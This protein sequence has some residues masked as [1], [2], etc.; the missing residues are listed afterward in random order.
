MT[1]K[2]SAV[3]AGR[4]SSAGTPARRPTIRPPTSAAAK[5]TRSASCDA[6][7]RRPGRR[8]L[9][10]PSRWPRRRSPRPHRARRSRRSPRTTVEP[11]ADRLD[12]LAHDDR[13]QAD[14]D[15]VHGPVVRLLHGR[16][17]RG[18]D[19]APA[20]RRRPDNTLLTP[21]T[22]NALF[23]MHGTTM[24]FLFVVPMMA[25]FAQLL[26][27]AD[28]RRAR[29][30]VPAPERAVVLAAARRR[31]RLLRLA[32]LQPAGVRLDAVTRRCREA[33]T[34][35]PAAS[36]RGSSWS[37]SPASARCS[38]R[39]TS[40]RRSPTCAR[41]AWAG[42]ACRCSC[43]AILTYSI[44]LILALPVDRRRRD[45]AAD[46]PA[47]RDALLR[48]DQRRLAAALAAPVLVLRAPR[49]L[50]HGAARA[51]GSSPRSCRS[52]RASRSSA[53]R[54][55][56]RRRVG[57]AFLGL[58][59]WAHHMFATPSPTVVLVFFML[60]S[61]LIAVPTGVKIFNWIATLWRGTIEFKTPMLFACGFLAHVPD[62][63]HHR[64]LPRRSSRSTGS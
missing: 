28:D 61:F 25:G 54:R 3:P 40:T 57:I 30:G 47:L 37:T 19:D 10:R 44:L 39:S 5:R 12:S 27:A 6:D 7:R 56:P 50:H 16:R 13:P 33:P 14:R 35:R 26:R 38:A 29:H 34:R 1:A 11:R 9:G 52:S 36:T 2:V 23:T 43:W 4:S 24:V 8:P 48:R 49:G 51:S 59:V 20:A 60:G 22:Y 46:R 42:A 32:V 64:H 21:Q 63:R 45:A 18:A 53:T 31:R 55:S 17:R 15:H 62:R 41:P 58:L